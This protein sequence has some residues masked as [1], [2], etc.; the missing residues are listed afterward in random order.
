[1]GAKEQWIQLVVVRTSETGRDAHLYRAPRF[2]CSPGDFVMV[3]FGGKK[4]GKVLITWDGDMTINNKRDD[5]M[6]IVRAFGACWPLQPII[7]RVV[8]RAPHWDEDDWCPEDDREEDDD[9]V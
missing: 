1:M 3:N 4:Q 2:M 6:D 5:V 7:G 9:S 8:E